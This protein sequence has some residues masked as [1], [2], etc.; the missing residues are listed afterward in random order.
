MDQPGLT[1]SN[2]WKILIIC[3]LSLQKYCN[4]YVSIVNILTFSAPDWDR[5]KEEIL[6]E[7][8]RIGV[9]NERRFLK[10]AEARE[11]LGGISAAKLQSLRVG[12][13]LPAINADG[14]WLYDVED[15]M[16]FIQRNKINSKGE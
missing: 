1:F 11:M 7:I 16:N 12:G 15:I 2:F 8:K 14:L 4:Q 5:F 13:H 10:S 3:H 9:K 6:E